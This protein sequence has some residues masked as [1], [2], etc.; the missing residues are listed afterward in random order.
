MHDPIPGTL[1]GTCPVTVTTLLHHA[2][3]SEGPK[4]PNATNV[5]LPS[6]LPKNFRDWIVLP[7]SVQSMHDVVP[8]PTEGLRP[9]PPWSRRKPE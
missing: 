7:I 8:C 3:H 6:V 5:Q 9:T 1:Q 2:S 4:F